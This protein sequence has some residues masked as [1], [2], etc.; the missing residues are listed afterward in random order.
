[1]SAQRMDEHPKPIRVGAIVLGLGE[2]YHDASVVL[3]PGLWRLPGIGP[4][5]QLGLATIEPKNHL[6]LR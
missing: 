6:L 3:L 1:M 2:D 4:F 5:F